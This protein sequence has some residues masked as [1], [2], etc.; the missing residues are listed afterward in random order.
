MEEQQAKSERE[1]E[2]DADCHVAVR[3]LVGKQADADAG[4]N[5]EYHQPRQRRRADEDR[6]R[7]AREAD[8]GKRMTREGLAAQDQEIANRARDDGDDPGREEGRAH[9]VI[10]QH[11]DDRA[12]EDGPPGRLH[13]RRRG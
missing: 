9:E 3:E 2:D 7:C 6:A 10:L 5:G 8:M 4:G 13:S 12:R 11:G 1:G